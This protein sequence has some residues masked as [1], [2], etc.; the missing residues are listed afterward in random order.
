M[1]LFATKTKTWLLVL[2]AAIAAISLSVS[3]AS[4][5]RK[6]R[7]YLEPSLIAGAKIEEFYNDPFST[8]PEYVWRLTVAKKALA[9]LRENGYVRCD[10][11]DST[12]AVGAVRQRESGFLPDNT[13]EVFRKKHDS[14]SKYFIRSGSTRAYLF[15]LC[16]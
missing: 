9:L 5:N 13:T 14:C 15:V 6:L 2:A 12:M 1:A 11:A 7:Q 8:D 4:P 16:F 3:L 10:D